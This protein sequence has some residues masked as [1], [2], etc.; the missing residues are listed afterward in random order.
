MIVDDSKPL[1][2]LVKVHLG[3]ENLVFHSAFNGSSALDM[4]A[5]IKPDLIL[6]DLDMPDMNGFDVCRFLKVDPSTANIP[7]IFLTASTSSDE[8]ACAFDSQATDYITKPFDSNE[9]IARVRVALR[10]KRL[11]DL[12]PPA[13]CPTAQEAGSAREVNSR[14]LDSTCLGAPSATV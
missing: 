10:T 4:V 8:K 3:E 5:S 13:N 2:A 14:P 6:L 12:L 11:L 7:V 9:L 1:H